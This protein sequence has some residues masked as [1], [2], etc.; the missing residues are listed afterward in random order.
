M[1]Y[2]AQ[3]SFMKP[4]EPSRAAPAAPWAE[5]LDA[6]RREP[7][8]E[9]QDQRRLGTD[10]DEV[11]LLFDANSTVSPSMSSAA[12]ATHSASSAI[13]ALPGAQK[14]LVVSG[15]A[16]I[17]QH[18]ACSRP[19]PAHH[20]ISACQPSP[21]RDAPWRMLESPRQHKIAA[22]WPT[23]PAICPEYTDSARSASRALK[24]TL[25]GAFER[26]R[27]RG[28]ISGFK[29]AGSGHL[30]FALKDARRSWMPSAGAPPRVG[31]RSRRRTGW[32]SSPSGVSPAIPAAPPISSWSRAWSWRGKARC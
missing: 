32:R 7:V 17:A 26:V 19:P 31:C 9:A 18:S 10:D 28:E 11:D 12:M 30:Y 24:R 14:S 20:Q 6:G 5:S 2:F 4:L 3:T 27:V 13:P 15:E 25:E 1:P 8:D 23:T 22:G 21:E 29:R 16:A